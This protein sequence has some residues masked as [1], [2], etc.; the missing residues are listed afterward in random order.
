MQ[1]L[2]DKYYLTAEIGLL[3][4][5]VPLLLYAVIPIY[6]LLPALWLSALYCQL[7]YRNVVDAPDRIFWS[8]HA[9]TW[10]NFK[11][12]LM[13]FI[14]A[15]LALAVLVLTLWPTQLFYMPIHRPQLWI[16]IMVAYPLLSVIPQEIIFRSFFFARYRHILPDRWSM[17]IASAAMFGVAHIIFQNWVAPI[18]CLVGGFFF[19]HT[20]DKH[21]SLLL[22]SIEHAM[23]GC[24]I[25]TL[26]LGRYFYHGLIGPQ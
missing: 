1:L 8:R 19:A 6:Y 20:Y 13:R 14:I 11:P 15:A 26:G 4:I 3:M 5:G 22:V 25:F 7:V 12:I 10:V 24:Y 21:R 16:L 23:Y 18:L 9:V 17:I 2:R